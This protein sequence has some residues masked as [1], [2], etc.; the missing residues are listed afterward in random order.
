MNATQMVADTSAPAAWREGAIHIPGGHLHIGVWEE[1]VDETA[2]L[3]VLRSL[4]ERMRSRGWAVE[5][6]T[7]HTN[8]R[9]L[10]LRRH[11]ARKG[12]LRYYASTSGRH[13][14]VNFFQEI[15]TE[16]GRGRYDGQYFRDMPRHLRIPCIVEMVAVIRKLQDCGYRLNPYQLTQGVP[17]PLA[18]LKLF[19]GRRFE[20]D[21]L[22]AFN[23]SWGGRRGEVRFDRDE[24]GWPSAKEVGCWH[25][26]D[27]DG[28][29][30]HQ[31]D[32]RY[33]RPT[34]LWPQ[35]KG[36]II[37]GQ[38]YGGINGQWELVSN[39]VVYSGCFQAREFFSC[40]RPDLEPRRLVPG[41]K[42]RLEKELAKA[43]EKKDWR[44]VEVLAGV[45]RMHR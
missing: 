26:L 16:P 19:D 11:L 42:D 25:P 35:P 7:A 21:P 23:D 20:G 27:R 13:L 1:N 8:Y 6:D 33:I 18:L 34:W 38:V 29:R 31:G 5:I 3:A 22:G 36:R 2:M 40:E 39:G 12:D 28:V 14:E 17:L 4:R 41:Q 44:R 10:Q 9:P 32:W 24:T 45:I 15:T 43:L 30:L 37:Y